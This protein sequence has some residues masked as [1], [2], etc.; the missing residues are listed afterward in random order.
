M[1]SI[2]EIGKIRKKRLKEIMKIVKITDRKT[3][4]KLN[5]N[6][7]LF[8]V[9]SILFSCFSAFPA[10][11]AGE[12]T[13]EEYTVGRVSSFALTD[14]NA[15]TNV[16]GTIVNKSLNNDVASYFNPYICT[17]LSFTDVKVYIDG[18]T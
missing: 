8:L 1:E 16:I 15:G 9:I 17:R 3:R 7:A 5:K 14:E 12:Y 18:G 6:A 11:S 4:A 13:I 2:R 10:R